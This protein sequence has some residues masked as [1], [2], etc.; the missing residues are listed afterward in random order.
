M[1]KKVKKDE[2]SLITTKI[3]RVSLHWLR[4]IAKVLGVDMCK[5]LDQ[6]LY[7][8][9][10]TSKKLTLDEPNSTNMTVLQTKSHYYVIF[11]FTRKTNIPK[12]KVTKNE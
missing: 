8:L 7:P 6:I 11:Q 3:S 5:V 4:H 12:E 9:Y 2:D 10:N 1:N